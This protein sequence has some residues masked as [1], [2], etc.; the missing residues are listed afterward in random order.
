MLTVA[1]SSFAEPTLPGIITAIAATVTA[2]GGLIVAFTVLLPMFRNTKTIHKIVNQQQTDLR[3]YQRALI[4][5]L[6]IHNIEIPPDQ[7]R[8]GDGSTA[9]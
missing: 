2:L 3:N 7:S 6:A 9:Q 5:T 4:E 1:A 8:G